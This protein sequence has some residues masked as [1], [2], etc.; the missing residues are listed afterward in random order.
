MLFIY[1]LEADRQYSQHV[2]RLLQTAHERGDRLFTSYLA[3]GE[4]TAGI[5]LY[6]EPELA[7]AKRRA[8]DDLGFSYIA[9]DDR[10]VVPFSTI[11][12][13]TRIKTADAIQLACAASVGMDLF[14]TGDRQLFGVSVPGI[15]KIVDFAWSEL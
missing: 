15:G 4:Y 14:V 11:R 5:K 7:S 1:F 13:S 6:A 2:E 8:M 9:F 12:S 10:A 3:V